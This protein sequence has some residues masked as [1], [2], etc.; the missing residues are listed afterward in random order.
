MDAGFRERL[1]SSRRVFEGRLLAVQVDEVEL[2]GGTRAQ[3]EIV[4][5]HPGAAV[6][7]PLL[8]E[9]KVVMLRHYRHAAGKVLLELPAGI[10][11]PGESPEECAHREL[12]EETGYAAGKLRHLFSA[13][14]SPGYSS[15]LAHFFLATGLR[16]Q[17]TA[18]TEDEPVELAI[19][20]LA[21]AVAMVARGE[22]QNAAAVCGLLAAARWGGE[23]SGAIE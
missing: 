15:E 9:G 20:P 23:A 18:P 11:N 1:I 17:G 22:V 21:E 5:R 8:P 19:L 3:R 7:A 16:A 10:L 4:A 12:I 6:I 14:L 2:P 13:Y